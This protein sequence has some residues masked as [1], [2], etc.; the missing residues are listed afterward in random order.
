M[1]ETTDREIVAQRAAESPEHASAQ[2]ISSV[3]ANVSTV[4]V[5]E[6]E[7]DGATALQLIPQAHGGAILSRP[8]DGVRGNPPPSPTARARDMMRQ[9]LIDL[10]P[11]FIDDIATGKVSKAQGL[12]ILAKYGIGATGTVTIVSPDV[13]QRLER[14]AMLIA[15][16]PEWDSR[17]LLHALREVW[18]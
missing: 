10:L 6:R 5:T 15:S 2:G 17:D 1:S 14:Q 18:A 8:P 12:D 7:S 4:D 9:G 11:G 16:R 3:A 13:L